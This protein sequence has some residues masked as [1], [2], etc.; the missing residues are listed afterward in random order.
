MTGPIILLGAGDA[1]EDGSCA[2]PATDGQV[3]ENSTNTPPG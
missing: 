1:C 2:L 3:E